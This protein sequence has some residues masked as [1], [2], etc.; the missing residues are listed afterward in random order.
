MPRYVKF[1]LMGK[2]RWGLV[3][4]GGVLEMTSSPYD[5]GSPEVQGEVLPWDLLRLDPP[6]EPT[7]VVAIGRNYADHAAELGNDVPAEPLLFIKPPSCVI[8]HEADVVYPT[9]QSELVHHEGELAIVIGRRAR[10]VDEADADDYILGYTVMNDVTARDLQRKDVQFTRA[11]SF[12]TFGPLGPWVDTD[13]APADQRIRVTV[14]GETR[15]ESTLD[16]MVFKPRFLLAYI[17]RVMTLEPGDVITTGTPSG[18]G[19]LLPG[20]EVEVTIA[21]L[22]ALKNRVVA[23]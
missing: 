11:K 8:G 15:Q 5:G 16:R 18:V 3:V 20:D 13:F 19:P 6:A 21:G 10:F 2:H 1:T 7:K 12:D 17:S 4:D 14:N 22:G 23:G 9:G